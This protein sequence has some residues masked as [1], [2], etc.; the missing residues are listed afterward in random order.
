MIY[1]KGRVTPGEQV[2]FVGKFSV[3]S[4][5]CRCS[6]SGSRCQSVALATL[7]F[8]P[9]LLQMISLTLATA[10]AMAGRRRLTGC[11]TTAFC[12]S[13]SDRQ[14]SEAE[15]KLVSTLRS[16]FPSA[17]AIIVE[18]VSG[19]CGAMFEVSVEAPDF[20]GVRLVN[21]HKMVTEA[22]E[23]EIKEMHG[24]RISTAV[25]PVAAQPES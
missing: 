16:R 14:P 4:V 9:T 3:A 2:Y 24:L 5:P 7:T 22:L 25:T 6:T 10:A 12:R 15:A 19:G 13:L 8:S 11:F 21:Q 1:K 23:K 17:S 18:D 20:K